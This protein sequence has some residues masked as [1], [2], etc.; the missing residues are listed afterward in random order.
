MTDAPHEKRLRNIPPGIWVLGF[1]SMLMD[2]SS[3]IIHS[4]LLRGAGAGTASA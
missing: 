3:E 1:V 2:I 4:L